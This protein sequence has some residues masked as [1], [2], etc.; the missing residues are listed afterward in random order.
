EFEVTKN[1]EIDAVKR[2]TEIEKRHLN[3]RMDKLKQEKTILQSGNTDIGEKG[4]L[5]INK[6]IEKNRL[7]YKALEQSLTIKPFWSVGTGLVSLCM[8]IFAIYLSLFFGSAVYKVLFEG[9]VIRNS[10]EAG[11]NPGLPQ[12]VDANAIIK[13]FRQ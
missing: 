6:D 2:S 13:I 8:S 12:L 9:N 10:L 11:V 1:K 3:E 7:E 4:L 5:Q